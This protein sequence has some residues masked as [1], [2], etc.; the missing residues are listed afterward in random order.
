MIINVA[1]ITDKNYSL[2]TATACNSIINSKN[3]DTVLRIYVISTDL[4]EVVRT[5]F[6]K[7]S[8]ADA[9]IIVVS[10]VNRLEHLAIDHPHVSSAALVKFDLP[11]IFPQLDRILYL[12]GDIVCLADLYD[13]YHLSLGDHY[14]AVVKDMAA[15][16]DEGHHSKMGHASYFNSGVMLLNL[17]KMRDD[18]IPEKLI[19]FKSQRTYQHFM[20]QDEFNVVFGENV[21]YMPPSHNLMERNFNHS[22]SETAQFYET[23]Y[24]KFKNMLYSPVLKHL[25]NYPKVWCRP[26]DRDF[27]LWIKYLPAPL[28]S[29]YIQFL[30][31]LIS[32]RAQQAEEK[33][34]Q[35]EE[36]AQQAEEKAQQAEEKAQQAEEK[37]Q[38][39]EVRSIE[40]CGQ[41]NAVRNSTSW[42][43]T[44]PLR[45]IGRAILRLRGQ[46][47][48]VEP[49]STDEQIPKRRAEKF[50]LRAA[51]YAKRYPALKRL[52]IGALSHMPNLERK[53]RLIAIESRRTIE[54]EQGDWKG[55]DASFLEKEAIYSSNM[56]PHTMSKLPFSGINASQCSPL[57]ANFHAYQ[58]HE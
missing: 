25:T 54:M 53:L 44:A 42:R 11:N 33:A 46:A 57:E 40:V 58:G 45:G 9:E 1:F 34:Q 21:I 10:T 3:K 47:P 5:C 38:Q 55:S 56:A 39:A 24:G 4:P 7:I 29:D 18:N 6:T 35:A 13:L 51:S 20:D 15:M 41:L 27:E 31:D 8:Q 23:E 14:A 30:D 26:K 2:A 48:I 36:K 43:V 16:V 52:L 32:L 22:I 17:S 12:D 28:V 50:V 19:E 49:R 37:A